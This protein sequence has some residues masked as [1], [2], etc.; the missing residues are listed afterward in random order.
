MNQRLDLSVHTL[1]KPHASAFDT[2]PRA[3]RRWVAELP[4]ANLDEM[5]Q[6]LWHALAEVNH[7]A[8]SPSRRL[9][10]LEAV[11]PKAV[12][13]LGHLRRQ[14]ANQP[15]PL[16]SGAERAARQAID[17]LLE[18]MRGYRTVLRQIAPD[19]A[20]T[21][22]RRLWSGHALHAA[23]HRFIHYGGHLLAVFQ[24]VHRDAPP[25]LWKRINRFYY[26]AEV[27]G[28]ATARL[29]LPS[30]PRRRTTPGDEYR[31][32]L[33][34]AL[35]SADSLTPAQSAELAASLPEW[36]KLTR[37]TRPPFRPDEQL[38]V[39]RLSHDS[40]P[41]GFSGIDEAARTSP[42]SRGLRM[43]E[44]EK[45]LKKRL[46]R[47]GRGRFWR[48]ESPL[49]PE[50]LRVLADN[51]CSEHQRTEQR[52][53]DGGA[54]EVIVGLAALNHLLG[55]RAVSAEAATPAPAKREIS[56]APAPEHHGHL[57]GSK[58]PKID[59]WQSV[60]IDPAQVKPA[61]APVHDWRQESKADETYRRLPGRLLD[62]SRH[63]CGVRVARDEVPHVAAGMLIAVHGDTP[64]D[65]QVGVVARL[66]AQD[67]DLELGV[68]LLGEAPVAATLHTRS[69]RGESRF[70]ALLVR[71][72]RGRRLLIGPAVPAVREGELAVELGGRRIA[73]NRLGKG[74][75]SPHVAV[76]AV[77]AVQ[78]AEEA[79][80]E[81]RP[82]SATDEPPSAP[83]AEK[84][85]DPRPS[86]EIPPVARVEQL[87]AAT[88]MTREDAEFFL[89]A[90]AAHD[91]GA[92]PRL[93]TGDR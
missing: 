50:T 77:A 41:L 38:H 58:A 78:A 82:Q 81:Q 63:G 25:G 5:T 35:L 30:E 8:I 37:L 47:G 20:I 31:R 73:L 67:T 52:R 42:N 18:L 2:R 28:Y 88:G 89:A 83:L 22:W 43:V 62:S 84:T 23:L 65:W 29:A 17:L 66:T 12:L 59:V 3:V 44:L 36:V 74:A 80:L 90:E 26:L 7:L 75:H 87:M 70:P 69:A 19:K 71:D 57:V 4:L 21:R 55:G 64:S 56:L 11:G 86:C 16:G 51:W 76:F 53:A 91:Q 34:T 72:E 93:K 85:A 39:V 79:L 13:A 49:S 32:L 48:R 68:R 54:A 27:N 14:Y 46:A 10:L 15:L 45:V 60:Y 24:A 6:R 9:H 92:P 33:L 61:V 40:G 1:A